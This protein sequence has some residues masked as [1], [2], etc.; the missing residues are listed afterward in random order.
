MFPHSAQT[1]LAAISAEPPATHSHI[2]IVS[3]KL[4]DA[5]HNYRIHAE[6]SS[7]LGRRAGINAI[8]VGEV[9]LAQHLVDSIALD[10]GVFAILHQLLHQHV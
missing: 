9:L 8:A 7:D 3:A 2:L 10:H 6:D 4:G 5:P 1:K